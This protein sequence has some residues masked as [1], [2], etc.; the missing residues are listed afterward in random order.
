SCTSE[1]ARVNKGGRL[2]GLAKPIHEHHF[3]ASVAVALDVGQGDVIRG[4]DPKAPQDAGGGQEIDRFEKLGV[5]TALA[6]SNA[7]TVIFA[8]AHPEVE[9]YTDGCRFGIAHQDLRHKADAVIQR[10]R[11]ACHAVKVGLLTGGK[12]IVEFKIDVRIHQARR[13]KAQ[14]EGG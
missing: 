8:P 6:E 7:D 9:V 4:A 1:V 3:Q 5:I 10:N 2:G 14:I 11:D 12:E 13:R